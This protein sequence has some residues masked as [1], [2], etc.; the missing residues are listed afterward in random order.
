MDAIYL[1]GILSREALLAVATGEGLHSQVYPL[2]PLKVV[3]AVEAL[4]ALV[5]FERTI[6]VRL[7][8]WRMVCTVHM[9]EACSMSTVEARHQA[10]RHAT[11]QLKTA[12]GV[13]D[14]R[15]NGAR[16]WVALERSL[17]MVR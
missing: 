10:M 14:I 15:K 3:V 12:T 9:L 16:Q 6:V 13:V 7:L 11:N 4:G 8:L 5:A 17:V 2:V 1:E